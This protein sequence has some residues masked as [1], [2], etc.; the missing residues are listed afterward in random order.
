[1]DSRVPPPITGATA[2]SMPAGDT[3]VAWNNRLNF[4]GLNFRSA[5]LVNA[6]GLVYVNDCLTV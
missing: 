6:S 1:M 2:K 5:G 3:D 4:N